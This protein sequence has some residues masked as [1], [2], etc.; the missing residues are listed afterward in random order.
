MFLKT[1][2]KGISKPFTSPGLESL[3]EWLVSVEKKRKENMTRIDN[4][5]VWL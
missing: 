2:A 4:W 3:E 1:S 5:T